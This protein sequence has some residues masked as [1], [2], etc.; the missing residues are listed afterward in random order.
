[1]QTLLDTVRTAMLSGRVY[2]PAELREITGLS[3]KYLIPFL[4]YCDRHGVTARQDSGR[5][6]A[7][8]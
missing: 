1:L 6:R 4:E 2:S 5:I 8:T 7:G 3:R